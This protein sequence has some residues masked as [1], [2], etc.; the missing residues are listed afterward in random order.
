MVHRPRT[1]DSVW[2][3]ICIPAGLQ[4]NP[5]FEVGPLFLQ[6]HINLN[7]L[8]LY[9]FP[10]EASNLYLQWYSIGFNQL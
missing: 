5:I 3:Q 7:P 6:I 4:S 8:S 1:R 9:K 10:L 2:K